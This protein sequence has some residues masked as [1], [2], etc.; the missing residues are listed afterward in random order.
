MPL[1]VAREIF[2][3]ALLRIVIRDG[4][5]IRTVVHAG[6]TANALQE[7]AVLV[8][9]GGR[10]ER[11]SCGLPISEIDHTNDWVRTHQTTLDDLAGL[12]GGDHDLKSLDGHRYTRRADGTIEWQPP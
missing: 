5:D 11:P 7:T 10:C 8:R 2:G 6:R 9:S 1:A 3:D 4:V 12:C